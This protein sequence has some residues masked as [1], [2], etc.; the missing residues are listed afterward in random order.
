[1]NALKVA[2]VTT[3]YP[4][5]NFGGD[6]VY[7][8][9]FAH[10]LARRG[11]DVHVLYDTEAFKTLAP[12]PIGPLEPLDEPPGV[13]VHALTSILGPLVSIITYESGRPIVHDAAINKFFEAPFDI[14]HFHNVSLVGGPGILSKG[15]GVRLYT[16][17]EHWLVCPTHILWRHNRELC[18]KRECVKC[19]LTYRRPPQ[20]WRYTGLLER[21]ARH[22]DAFIALSQSSAENHKEFGFPFDMRVLPSFLPEEIRPARKTSNSSDG[23]PY[24]LFV[25][26]L[27]KLKGLQDLIPV[28][29][30]DPAIDLLIVGE[31]EYGAEL[32]RMAAGAPHIRFLGKKPPEALGEIY[33]GAVAVVMPSVCYEVFPLVALEAFRAGV[34]IVARAL[35]PFPEIIEKSGAGFLFTDPDEARNAVERLIAD[36]QLRTDLGARGR[37][38]VNAHWSERAAMTAYFN[39]VAEK[40]D[41]KGLT[42]LSR[43]ARG[44]ASF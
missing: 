32:R 1:M 27:E 29:R 28:F 8:R 42:D 44:L 41:G 25:G 14:T 12:R 37:I 17:H 22:I 40:A 5:H 43:K 10:A 4:P 21:E 26:R 11:C 19:Q 2:L 7:V 3:F 16:A 38:A 20:L 34:P 36:P 35:G 18:D 30:A 6:G 13:T 9:R 15:S 31:G 39:L 23:R 33:A 24:A